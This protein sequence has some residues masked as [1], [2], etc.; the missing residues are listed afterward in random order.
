MID[1]KTLKRGDQ[2]LYVPTHANGDVSH[3]DVESGFVT[4]VSNYGVFC[5]FWSK[6]DPS[7]LRTKANSE[8]AGFRDVV[9]YDSHPVSVVNSM[10]DLYC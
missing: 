7:E 1:P 6:F 3:P 8:R 4:S 10:L 5:R 9:R 2:I